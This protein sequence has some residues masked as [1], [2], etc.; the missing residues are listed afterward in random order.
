MFR[1]VGARRRGHLV[2]SC[3]QWFRPIMI[4]SAVDLT[5]Q[6]PVVVAELYWKI[7]HSVIVSLRAGLVAR[8]IVT[9]SSEC[10]VIDFSQ[11]SL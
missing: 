3:V 8:T 5:R 2:R 4:A 9:R 1:P 11:R 7:E 10:S 6:G